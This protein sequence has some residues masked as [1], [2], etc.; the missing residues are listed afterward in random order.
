MSI[1]RK[2]SRAEFERGLYKGMAEEKL[3]KELGYRKFFSR[4][5]R[6]LKKEL[7]YMDTAV[8]DI[9]VFGPVVY[10]IQRL[11]D[12]VNGYIDLEYT[13]RGLK[14]PPT[15]KFGTAKEVFTQFHYESTIKKGL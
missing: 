13:V 6:K 12:L 11:E 7:E 10:D 5:Y 14:N 4:K 2:K 3:R 1:L 8:Y 9:F 15:Y